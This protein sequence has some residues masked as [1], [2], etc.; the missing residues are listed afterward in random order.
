MKPAV[1]PPTRTRAGAVE[2]A[3]DHHRAQVADGGGGGLAVGV[4]VD[5][6]LHQCEVAGPVG[7][8]GA[9]AKGTVGGEV[10]LQ[11]GD[12]GGDHRGADVAVDHDLGRGRQAA[13]EVPRQHGERLLGL[14]GVG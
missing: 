11:L 5:R 4:A 8:D 14:D 13:G 1:C 9:G 3:G 7:L 2:G 10:G 12:G 6:D